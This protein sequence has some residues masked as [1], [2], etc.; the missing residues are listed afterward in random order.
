M[1]AWDDLKY[2]SAFAR[3]GSLA[4]AARALGVEHATVARRIAA[5]EATLAMKLV[6]RRGRVYELTEDGSKVSEF[7]QQMEAASFALQRFA[8]GEQSRVEGEV[9][10]SAPPAH[11]GSLVAPRLGAM[12]RQHPALQ[13]RL[14]GAK[15]TASLAR[16]ETDIAVTFSR[17]QESNVVAKRLGQLDFWLYASAEY[18]QSH[19]PAQ[20]EF[21]GYDHGMDSWPQ[22]QWLL[23]QLQ[24]RPLVLT[25]NDLR[26]QAA[27][28]VGDAGV[29]LLPDF[30]GREYGLQRVDDQG[31]AVDI[32]IW[33]AYHADLR[34]TARIRVVLDF[35][36]DCLSHARQV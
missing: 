29:V 18:L 36:I 7:A 16:K 25:S 3:E 22:Q 21:I 13:V 5:L 35:L 26:I 8:G 17:P 30:L 10:I 9:V 12:R 2:L 20:F 6:D 24:G 19:S 11:L 33:I 28:A 23:N 27:A 32:P 4:A 15:S 31:P 1:F 14:V 34:G